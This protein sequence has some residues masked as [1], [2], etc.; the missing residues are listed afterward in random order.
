MSSREKERRR[1]KKMMWRGS[2]VISERLTRFNALTVTFTH[3][4]GSEKF[5]DD[6]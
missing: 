4:A 2:L 1:P 3:E 6:T 5:F